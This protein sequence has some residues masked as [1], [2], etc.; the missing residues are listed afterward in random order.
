MDVDDVWFVAEGSQ[1]SRP[2]LIRGRQNLSNVAGIASHPKLF[3]IVWEYEAKEE[4]GLPSSELNAS[5]ADFENVIIAA[6]E[7]DFLCVFFCVYVHNGV[8]EWTAYTSDVQATCDRF[9][10]VLAGRKPYPVEHKKGTFYFILLQHGDRYDSIYAW[11]ER[12]GQRRVA[13]ATMYSI[14]ATRGMRCF[15]RRRT[16]PRFSIWWRRQESGCQCDCLP[17]ACFRTIFIW[18][19]G[20]MPTGT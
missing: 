11:H 2:V 1:D 15:T 16:S 6:L 17:G 13:F 10:A 7:R 18:C 3:R 14:A 20:R 4:S 12:Q 8:K 19:C 9:N 5:M